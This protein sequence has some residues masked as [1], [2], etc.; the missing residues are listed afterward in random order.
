MHQVGVED[1]F[2]QEAWECTEAPRS[3]DSNLSLRVGPDPKGLSVEPSRVSCPGLGVSICME[4]DGQSSLPDPYLS[5]FPQLSP[6]LSAHRPDVNQVPSSPWD[7]DWAL[8]YRLLLQWPCKF[9]QPSLLTAQPSCLRDFA[10]GKSLLNVYSANSLA[11]HPTPTAQ[12]VP[13]RGS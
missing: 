11:S 9:Q 2:P 13:L 7:E 1:G 5:I 4:E 8:P 10:Q 12:E 6:V 3:A